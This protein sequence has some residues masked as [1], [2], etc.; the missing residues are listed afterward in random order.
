M[1]TFGYIIIVRINRP[2]AAIVLKIIHIQ[3]WEGIFKTPVLGNEVEVFEMV[4]C[5]A[6]K[7]PRRYPRYSCFIIL[8]RSRNIAKA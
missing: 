3:E 7:S 6:A 4:A 5:T 1:L 8:T 2:V